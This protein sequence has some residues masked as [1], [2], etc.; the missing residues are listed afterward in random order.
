MFKKF[1][2]TCI[3]LMF[4]IPSAAAEL[5]VTFIN[6]GFSDDNPTGN[7][8]LNVTAFM[9]AAAE[10]LNIDLSVMYAN[11]NHIDMKKMVDKALS[12]DDHYL[13]LVDEKSVVAQ[14]LL[15]SQKTHDKI[16]FLLN[17]PTKQEQIRLR[18]KGFG[19]LGNIVPDNFQAGRL[20]IQQLDSLVL[21]SKKNPVVNSLALLG[22]TATEA[23]RQREQ[24][25]LSHSNRS[26]NL[27]LQ[28]RIDANWSQQEA[29]RITKGLL[30]RFPETK[31]IWAANDAMAKGA[32]EA[33]TKLSIRQQ[34]RIGGVNWDKD[35]HKVLDASV[36]G[37]V[38]LG[39]FTLV[40]IADHFN[41]PAN[42]IGDN[43]LPIFKVYNNKYEPLYKA[44]HSKTL[45]KIDFRYFSI[46]HTSPTPK[47]FTLD[48]MTALVK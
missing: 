8:W 35:H 15:S 19:I 24:G 27:K 43:E 9:Q 14:A 42:I 32:A 3:F 22:E 6:P 31:L 21:R 17:A 13:V 26:Y 4:A 41:D 29:Y 46:T 48:N 5:K 25:L 33:A 30:K 39:A 47:P 18:S 2:L 28:Q 45:D 12:R 20:L 7:F 36:G 1:A 11:R 16:I 23:A 40:K 10:D 44:I 38:T 37:H 34:I